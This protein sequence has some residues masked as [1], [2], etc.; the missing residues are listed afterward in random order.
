MAKFVHAK[1]EEILPLTTIL[2]ATVEEALNALND[3]DTRK[4]KAFLEGGLNSL[5]KRA[6]QIQKKDVQR[7]RELRRESQKNRKELQDGMLV[8]KK[9]VGLRSAGDS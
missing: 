9:F 7:T 1:P 3:G 4:A 5:E 8:L 6:S 2:F